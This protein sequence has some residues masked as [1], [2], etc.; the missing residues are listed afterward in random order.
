MAG[1]FQSFINYNPILHPRY[2]FIKLY[3]IN[4]KCNNLYVL[5]LYRFL[6]M[7]YEQHW[8]TALIKTFS[9]PENSMVWTKRV[10]WTQMM[11]Y[12]YMLILTRT[13]IIYW[14]KTCNTD[15]QRS[16]IEAYVK[17]EETRHLSLYRNTLEENTVF[18]FRAEAV[19]FLIGNE[20]VHL[21]S[22]ISIY[23]NTL[24]LNCED[25]I[26]IIVSNRDAQIPLTIFVSFC[27]SCCLVAQN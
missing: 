25:H 27:R 6:A 13:N 7:F 22:L 20:A 9:T 16:I 23:Q 12:T 19:R 5:G 21:Q 18:I 8:S 11:Q 1:F 17:S 2:I 24:I 26:T 3:E 4:F 14:I 10:S 15:W